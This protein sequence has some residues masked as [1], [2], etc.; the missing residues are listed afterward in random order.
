MPRTCVVC[1]NSHRSEID[2]R[3]AAGASLRDIAGHFG[4]SKSAL[5]RHREHA[6]AAIAK[7]AERREESIGA[8]SLEEIGRIQAKLWAVFNR[9][10]EEKDHR[11]QIVALREARETAMALVALVAKSGESG[12]GLLSPAE[13]K[14]PRDVVIGA[15]GHSCP[16]CGQALRP[17]TFRVIYEDETKPVLDAEIVGELPGS[18]AIERME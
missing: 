4:V 18:S 17:L 6:G 15:D 8:S 11:G 2:K 12:S 14:I 13:R 1:S 3:L 5:A 16:T 10:E 7:A 9:L